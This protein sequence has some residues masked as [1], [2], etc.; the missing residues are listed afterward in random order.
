MHHEHHARTT[1]WEVESTPH[2]R[3]ESSH[4]VE[5]SDE[6]AEVECDAVLVHPQNGGGVCTTARSEQE[7]S[8]RD[9]TLAVTGAAHVDLKTSEGTLVQG[10]TALTDIKRVCRTGWN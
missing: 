2:S 5:A 7:A 8:L 10:T 9:E 6:H 4:T 3:H 1:H